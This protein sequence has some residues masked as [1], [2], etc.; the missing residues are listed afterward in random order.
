MTG[1]VARR[2]RDFA[3]LLPVMLL[4]AAVIIGCWAAALALRFDGDVP[5]SRS[6][7]SPRRPGS[8]R[9]PTSSVT[10]FFRIYRTS[11]KYAGIVD[12]VN[13]ALSIGLVSIFL[14]AINVFLRP[15]HIPLTVNVTAPA[16]MLIAMGG[17]KFWP[18][19]WAVA[20]PV[21]RLRR[22]RQ[23]RADRRR[24]PHRPALAREFLQNPRWQ[25]RPIGFIDD[26][27]RL[28]GVRI[29]SVTVLGDR[30]DIP[31]ICSRK[32]VDLVALAIPSAGGAA[33][34]DVVG[35][36]PDDAACPCAPCP[37]S[38]TSS[39]TKPS[40]A[41]LREVTVDDLLGRE[42]VDI[43]AELCAATI[44]GKSVLIT[45]AAGF[46]ASELA[47]QVLAFGPATAASRRRQRDRALRPRSATSRPTSWTERSARR[48][49]LAVRCLRPRSRSTRCS[50]R[51]APTSSSTPPRTSTSPSWRSTRTRRCGRTSLGTLNVCAAA[52]EAGVAKMVFVSTDKA[53][54]PD[55]VYGATK[56]IGELLVT[57]FGA[58]QPHDVS[59][60][61]ASAT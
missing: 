60:P 55:N 5:S 36:V 35:I 38:A 48:A 58:R 2:A 47:R 19:L 57:A 30:F 8:S 42:Q 23:E 7:S 37:A 27:R 45:G 49:H 61:C 4:D 33:I 28:R 13:L 43:D 9:W 18:R 16:L 22:R 17:I 24:R 3:R 32:R 21:R 41:D 53:V 29:H 25:Y 12:A 51:R 44:R 14:F 39:A 54:N 56:R 31:E 50:R 40:C 15:R 26:D 6:A 11:W 59:P 1:A 46:I 52:S 34:R 10:I 20:Q